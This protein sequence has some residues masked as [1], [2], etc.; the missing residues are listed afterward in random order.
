MSLTNSARAIADAGS[1]IILATVEIVAPPERVFR[2][3]TTPDEIVRWWG[4]DE[5]YRMTGWTADLRVGGRWRA[6]GRGADGQPFAVEGEFLEV[7]P[8]HKLVQ[9]WK[10]GWLEGQIKTLAYRLEAT[11]EGTRLI[12]RHEG[13]AR[14]PEA[15]W[16]HGDGWL[17]VLGWLERHILPEP[18]GAAS[19]F[20]FC[21]LLPPR[22]TFAQDMTAGEAAVIMEHV[23]YWDKHLHIGT[24]IV[25]GPV[26]DPKGA[27]GLG[28]VRVADEA[29]VRVFEAK[30][31][32]DPVQAWLP[33]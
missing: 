23:A 5:A 29:A 20:F 25:F 3:L 24:A 21:R 1:G 31:P 12:V 17:L 8:P 16:S 30:R 2:A 11:A 10:P 13:F 15:C 4:S 26:A 33:L 9:T 19:R 32:G 6:E 18:G 14:H 27:W 28:V 22:P 7:D